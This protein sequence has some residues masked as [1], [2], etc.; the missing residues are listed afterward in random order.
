MVTIQKTS[1]W[2]RYFINMIIYSPSETEDL[3]KGRAAPDI[4]GKMLPFNLEGIT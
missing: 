2:F 4:N 3:P 1:Q